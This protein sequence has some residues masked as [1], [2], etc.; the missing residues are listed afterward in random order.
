M[1]CCT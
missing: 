1:S